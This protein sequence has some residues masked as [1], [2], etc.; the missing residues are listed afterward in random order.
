MYTNDSSLPD[1][2]VVITDDGDAVDLSTGYTFSLKC[3]VPGQAALFTKS[4]G[5]TGTTTGVTIQWATSGEL[6][7]LDPG[8]YEFQLTST[9]GSDSRKRVDKWTRPILDIIT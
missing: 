2:P 3:G 7:S 6:L 1:T 5:I 9:R 4:S 8:V